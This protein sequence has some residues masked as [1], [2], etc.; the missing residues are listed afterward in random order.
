MR[1][2]LKGRKKPQRTPEHSAKL[3]RYTRTDEHRSKL[4]EVRKSEIGLYKR[5]DET[6]KRMGDWQRGIPKPKVACE[7]CGKHISL[8][9]YRRWHGNN[10]K[11][12]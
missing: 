11:I 8:M 4:A 6:K 3:G 12:K 1:S 2:K 10:C 9:N 7:C 5:S